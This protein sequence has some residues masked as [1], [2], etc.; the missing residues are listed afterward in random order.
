[1]SENKRKGRQRNRK[2]RRRETGKRKGPPKGYQTKTSWDELARRLYDSIGTPVAL[3]CKMLLDNEEYEQLANKRIDDRDYNDPDLFALDA[4]AVAFLSKFHELPTGIDTAAA[5]LQSFR[6]A[7]AD[8]A[9]TNRRLIGRSHHSVEKRGGVNEVFHLA[10]KKIASILGDVPAWEDLTYR[11]GPGSSYGVRGETAPFNKLS[12]QP[13]ASLNMLSNLGNICKLFPSWLSVDASQ[14]QLVPGS[15]LGYARKNATTDRTTG[16]EP[17]MNGLVQKAQGIYIGGRL[18]RVGIDLRDQSVNQKLAATA[19]SDGSAT[20]DLKGASDRNAYAL[21]LELFP[22][23]WVEFLDVTRSPFYLSKGKWR[24]F[25]KFTSMGNA[26]TFEVETL[27]FYALATASCEVLGIYHEVGYNLAVYGDDIIIPTE[28][29]ELLHSSLSYAGHI[30]NESKTHVK[31]AFFESCGR[32]YFL[33]HEVRPVYLRRD[34]TNVGV[35]FSVTN[36]VLRIASTLQAL[37][38]GPIGRKRSMDCVVERLRALHR[39][40][41]S[42]IPRRLRLLGPTQAERYHFND[43]FGVGG[44]DAYLEADFDV[45]VPQRHR[46]WDGF[47][48]S[49]LVTQP[50]P[51]P[52]P[53]VYSVRD[54]ANALYFADQSIGDPMN[55]WDYLSPKV[56]H[57]PWRWLAR[58]SAFQKVLKDLPRELNDALGK[59][60]YTVRDRTCVKRVECFNNGP[61]PECPI[62]WTDEAIALVQKE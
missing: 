35:A 36:Q 13:D 32:D 57:L 60:G 2:G 43:P 15:R 46:G 33:G 26:Y 7:E 9:R 18:R 23:P 12:A 56:K 38:Q 42:G 20:V 3:S 30:V 37:P 19:H 54:R 27:I 16:A 58:T 4:Q 28:A 62:R 25:H 6:D 52:Y 44:T 48:Y 41:V 45:A 55:R 5:A 39:W 10:R 53:N 50:V 61:W 17:T 29:F 1:M 14:V 22:L 59:R 51:R 49:A 40:C 47:R 11:F 24:E 31:G 8:C 21:I 34:I